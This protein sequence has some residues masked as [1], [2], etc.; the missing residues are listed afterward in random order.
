MRAVL[1][2]CVIFPP[3]LR[4]MLL[5]V[6]AQGVFVPLWSERILEEWAR[7]ARRHGSEDEARA[8]GAAMR[9]QFASATVPPRP[10]LEARLH[11]PDENDIHVLATAIAGSADVIVTFNAQD[12]PRHI[13]AAEGVERRDPDSLLWEMWSHHPAPVAEVAQRV[14]RRAE[15]IAGQPVSL[16][17]LLKRAGLPRV[18]KAVTA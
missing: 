10:G 2:T 17:A 15:E 8:V 1:D 4:D 3:V 7:A 9:A 13:L 11:L 5:G 6:A 12:F 18:A 16:R 14:H